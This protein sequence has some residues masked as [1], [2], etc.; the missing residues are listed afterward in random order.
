MSGSESP[1]RPARWRIGAVIASV[2]AAFSL[3]PAGAATT[4]EAAKTQLQSGE[5]AAALTAATEGIADVFN[6]RETWQLI[7]L[8]ALMATGQYVEALTAVKEA[9]DMDPRSLRLKWAAREVFQAN[10][11]TA[12]ARDIPAEIQQLV[13]P[14]SYT[15][16]TLPTKRIV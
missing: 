16:L 15:H 1:P 13:T 9:L 11:D 5:Y 6:D 8:E 14:V 2:G 12:A 7:R 10:G 3:A 4:E